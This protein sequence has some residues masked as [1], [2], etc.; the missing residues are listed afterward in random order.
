MI[1]VT[2]PTGLI[3]HHVVR[4]LLTAG[5]PLEYD[6]SRWHHRNGESCDQ[7]MR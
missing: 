7:T 3:G 6:P 1:V 5:A 2:A 4:D